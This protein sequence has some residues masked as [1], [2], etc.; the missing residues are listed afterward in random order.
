MSMRGN[1]ELWNTAILPKDLW[2]QCNSNKIFHRI[3]NNAHTRQ[4]SKN[5][6]DIPGK[7]GQI[8]VFT[9]YQDLV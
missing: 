4:R 2:S 7:E 3:W 6:G 1:T 5:N 9:R 8:T